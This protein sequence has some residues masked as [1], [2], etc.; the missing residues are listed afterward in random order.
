MSI[1]NTNIEER[2]R[3]HQTI[4]TLGGCD[5]DSHEIDSGDDA[6]DT[7]MLLDDMFSEMANN[8]SIRDAEGFSFST[9]IDTP[10]YRYEQLLELS[11]TNK[12]FRFKNTYHNGEKGYSIYINPALG[13]ISNCWA[14]GCDIGEYNPFWLCH[15]ERVDAYERVWKTFTREQLH[16]HKAMMD[17]EFDGLVTVLLQQKV[18]DAPKTM[19]YDEFISTRKDILRAVLDG[20]KFCSVSRYAIPMMGNLR[21]IVEPVKFYMEYN[22]VDITR[23]TDGET[24][25]AVMGI[26]ESQNV[27]LADDT[28]V[29]QMVVVPIDYLA[30]TY[31]DEW[32]DYI[33]QDLTK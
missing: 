2:V 7:A 32:K 15:D 26:C 6:L 22:I 27:H 1:I 4:S 17:D 29:P 14:F 31:K 19:S 16:K 18:L 13:D 10:E 25:M 3:V 21:G 28:Q 11:K 24:I 5:I 33:C 12:Q 20:S 23:H 8:A 30:Y 9:N